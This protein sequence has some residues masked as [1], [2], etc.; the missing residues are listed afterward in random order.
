[1]LKAA[2]WFSRGGSGVLLVGLLRGMLAVTRR[3]LGGSTRGVL[4]CYL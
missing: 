1:V 3:W 4:H 2:T